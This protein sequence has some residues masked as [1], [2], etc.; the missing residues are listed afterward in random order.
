MDLS[1]SCNFGLYA[2][3][4]IVSGRVMNNALIDFEKQHKENAVD[5]A[6]RVREEKK[7][8]IISLHDSG[9]SVQEIVNQVK[10]QPLYVRRVLHMT[11][12]LVKQEKKLMPVVRLSVNGDYIDEYPSVGA[13]SRLLRIDHECIRKCCNKTRKTAGGFVFMYLHTFKGEA[14]V[15]MKRVQSDKVRKPVVMLDTNGDYIQTFQSCSDAA[16]SISCDATAIINVCRGRM[17]TIKRFRFL[18]AEDYERLKDTDLSV[19][20]GKLKPINK[21]DQSGKVVRTY[22]SIIETSRETGLSIFILR[23][24]MKT[25]EYRDGFTFKHKHVRAA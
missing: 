4:A 15:E 10:E 18:Y 25:G 17:K 6:K 5:R 20:A 22:E 16:K 11:G 14:D 9:M 24:M 13:A 19:T 8:L 2:P 7:E 23:R 12:R 1:W 3:L 21:I